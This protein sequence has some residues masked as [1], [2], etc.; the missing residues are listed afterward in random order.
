M[1]VSILLTRYRMA[2]EVAGSGAAGNVTGSSTSLGRGKFFMEE[3][4]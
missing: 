4:N 3:H 2:S 1:L